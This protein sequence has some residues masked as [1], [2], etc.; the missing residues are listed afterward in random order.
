ML[1][2]YL[3]GRGAWLISLRR[4]EEGGEPKSG[5]E[6]MVRSLLGI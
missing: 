5:G 1:T 3:L 2:D 4:V 6:Q